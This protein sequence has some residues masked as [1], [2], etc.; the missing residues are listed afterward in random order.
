MKRAI[1]IYCCLSWSF[2]V[3]AGSD[4]SAVQSIVTYQTSDI[5]ESV[6]E[7][8]EDA[9]IGRG[10]VIGRTLHA[11]EMLD[12]TGP[13]LGFPRSVCPFTVAVY[14]RADD[15]ATC[16]SPS[17]A[18]NPSAATAASPSTYSRCSTV[19]RVRRLSDGVPAG[20]SFRG[21]AVERVAAV[22]RRWF[23]CPVGARGSHQVSLESDE[24]AGGT[25]GRH[26]ADHRWRV[27]ASISASRPRQEPAHIDRLSGERVSGGLG[28]R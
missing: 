4:A 12:R 28:F 7:N 14:V 8:V 27:G 23:V 15:P 22:R 25:P 20:Q 3:W 10:M 5:F 21:T 1:L 6:K 24:S 18:P 11:R 26:G 16:S 13:D 19:L 2:G 17:A 9:I